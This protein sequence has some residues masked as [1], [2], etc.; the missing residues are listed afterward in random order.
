MNNPAYSIL[1]V[2]RK[3]EMALL[4]QEGYSFNKIAKMYGLSRQRVH[5]ILKKAEQEGCDVKKYKQQKKMS[6]CVVCKKEFLPKYTRKTC[7]KECLKELREQLNSRLRGSIY[8]RYES[9]SLTC[10]NCNKTFQRT[11]HLEYVVSKRNKTT[12]RFCCRTCFHTYQKEIH[13]RKISSINF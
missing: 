2:V 11:K 13:R 12:N 10:K 3:K 8:S 1:A 4:T 5:Q 7:G 6:T 9:I